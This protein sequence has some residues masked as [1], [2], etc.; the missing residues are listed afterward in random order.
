MSVAT[1]G[2]YNSRTEEVERAAMCNKPGH[3][4]RNC[5]EKI[6]KDDNKSQY[7]DGTLNTTKASRRKARTA[8]PTCLEKL[9]K[10]GVVRPKV[11]RNMIMKQSPMFYGMIHLAKGG[12]GTIS[13]SI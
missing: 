6:K 13:C 10:T 11:R 8:L 1:Q 3:I 5:P 4:A 9:P 2:E 12:K 7:E